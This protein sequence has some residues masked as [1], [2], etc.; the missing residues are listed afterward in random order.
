MKKLLTLLTFLWA[1]AATSVPAQ[2]TIDAVGLVGTIVDPTGQ[3]LNGHLTLALNL[4]NVK[5]ICTPPP[6]QVAPR[7]PITF[8]VSNGTIVNGSTAKIITQDC[9]SPRS[10]Y[11]VSLY[12]QNNKLIFADNWYLHQEQINNMVRAQDVGTMVSQGFGGPIVIAV[13]Q[14]VVTNPQGDQKITQPA[15]TNLIINSAICTGTCIG[16]GGGGTGGGSVSSVGLT[17]PSIFNVTQSPVTGAG[18]LVATL[19]TEPAGTIFAGP[20]TGADATPSFRFL[21]SGDIPNN[22]ANTTGTAGNVTG[23]VAIANGGTGTSSPGLVQGTGIIITGAWPNQTVN[24]SLVGNGLPTQLAVYGG[25]S[26]LGGDANITDTG[27]V[28]T[29]T[30]Q[31]NTPNLSP[32]LCVATDASSN[33]TTTTCGGANQPS[34]ITPFLGSF[35]SATSMD[36]GAMAGQADVTGTATVQTIVPKTGCVNGSAGPTCIYYLLSTNGFSIQTSITGGSVN[37]I[38]GGQGPAGTT[39]LIPQGAIV[40]FFYDP[41]NGLWHLLADTVDAST[42]LFGIIPLTNIDDSSLGD[43]SVLFKDYY[44]AQ[45]NGTETYSLGQIAVQGGQTYTSLVDSNFNNTPS[46][47]LGVDW[48]SIGLACGQTLCL[49]P[50]SATVL[51]VNQSISDT[52]ATVTSIG[53]FAPTGA[54]FYIDTEYECYQYISG[55]TFQGITRGAYNTVPAAHTTSSPTGVNGA[56]VIGNQNTTPSIVMTAGYA[57]PMIVGINNSFPNYHAGVGVLSLNTGSNET[58]W[59]TS[60]AVHQMNNATTNVFYGPISI[61]SNAH[62]PSINSSGFVMQAYV[63]NEMYSPQGFG[64]GINGSLNINLVPTLGQPFIDDFSGGGTATRTYVCSATDYDGNSIPGTPR[65][66]TTFANSF[67]PSSFVSVVCP[68]AAG[69]QSYQVWRTAGGPNQGFLATLASV[70]EAQYFDFNASASGGTPPAINGSSPKLSIAG[71]SHQVCD[72]STNP[73]TCMLFGAG[74]PTGCGT[75]YGLGSTYGNETGTL[76]TLFYICSPPGTQYNVGQAQASG[77]NVPGANF[78]NSVYEQTGSNS[79]GYSVQSASV[80][81]GTGGTNGDK[82]DVGII[83]APSSTTQASSWLCHGTYTETSTSPNAYVTVPLT[84]CGTL[85]PNTFVW[86]VY[87]TND[88]GV[89][90]GNYNCGGTCAGAAGSSSYGGRFVASTYGTYTGLTTSLSGPNPTQ[91]SAYVSMTGLQDEWVNNFSSGGS[92]NINGGGGSGGS[93]T[94]TSVGLSLPNIFTTSGSPVTAAGTLTAVFAGGQ[95]ANLFLA[96]PNGTSGAFS[97]RAV[98]S[99]DLP[100]FNSSGA[101]IV[102]AS[103]GGSVNYLRADGTWASPAG[104]GG[105][106]LFTNIQAGTNT[107]QA[108][109]VGNGSSLTTSGGG[110]ISA[111]TVNNNTYPG[112]ASITQYGVLYGATTSSVASSTASSNASFALFASATAPGFRAITINDWGGGAYVAAAGSVNVMTA[113]L[114][115]APTALFTGMEVRVLPNNT[116]TS[117]TPTL[118]VNGFGAVTIT[119]LGHTALVANDLNTVAIADLIYDGTDWQLQNPQTGSSGGTSIYIHTM[120]GVTPTATVTSNTV[121]ATDYFYQTLAANS[122]SITLPSS[123]NVSDGQVFRFVLSQTASGGPFTLPTGTASSPL[124]AGS[125]TTLINTI[126]GGC[127]SLGTTVSGTAPSQL[128]IDV[129][130][131]GTFT[132]YQV[133]GCTTGSPTQTAVVEWTIDG[134]ALG[135]VPVNTVLASDTVK[136]P[137]KFYNLEIV[138]QNGGTCTTAPTFNIFDGTT[139]IGTGIAGSTTQ[140]TKGVATDQAETL[141]FNAGDR[142]GI[143]LSSAGA[144]CTGTNFLATAHVG[145]P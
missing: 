82:I 24:S 29:L 42:G 16:F 45:W 93:G 128:F 57:A 44:R 64:G 96:S 123:A 88:A 76:A 135:N 131:Q 102:P 106:P 107:G 136:N 56:I 141:P 77:T 85:T 8:Q 14:G 127:P 60:G 41:V 25:S 52:T 119:K 61:S 83:A 68:Q 81:V 84:G 126:P 50:P 104:S 70:Q 51:A 75:S 13:G 111:T 28:I 32:N 55:N 23:I 79:G 63:P 65:T 142:I 100:S 109:V 124:T 140:Q 130:Y 22:A 71:T 90:I 58:W 3:P 116:N 108:L 59:D 15:G 122:T 110:T 94:V 47:T 113:T 133:F 49:T 134:S 54:C 129:R 39:V 43:T 46:N 115:P 30:G 120:T 74:V 66:G 7:G 4:A 86:V 138:N 33:L 99:A 2:Q 72:T 35:A 17:L 112:N 97:A 144:T 34:A 18:N 95:T 117:T 89:N 98:V 62:V 38:N 11:Y 5:N 6:Y 91:P 78:I 143:Y 87:N 137:G 103:G 12:D 139:N 101:G 92:I 132:E 53:N 31:V 26:V 121:P 21:Q 9:M 10:A 48:A 105:S 1:F 40:G 118:N 125:G 73:Q 19:S 36:F 69:I 67:S 145:E 37:N 27:S 114:S 80:Y 20:G